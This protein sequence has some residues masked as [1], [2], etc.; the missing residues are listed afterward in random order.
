MP[1]TAVIYIYVHIYICICIY[2]RRC[3]C[4]TLK[5]YICKY[6]YV[7]RCECFKLYSV[8]QVRHTLQKL[9]TVSASHAAT[10]CMRVRECI[11]HI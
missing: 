9:L 1:H 7:Q 4:F 3:E 2:I 8:L 6:I 5:I 11:G 10:H